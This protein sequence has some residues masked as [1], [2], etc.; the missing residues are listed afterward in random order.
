MH[1]ITCFPQQPCDVEG[2]VIFKWMKEEI[3]PENKVM[4][5]GQEPRGLASDAELFL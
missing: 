4:S 3:K 2:Q 1:H 5:R